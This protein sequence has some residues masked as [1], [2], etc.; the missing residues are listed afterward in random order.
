M[1]AVH[2]SVRIPDAP[3]T[4]ARHDLAAHNSHILSFQRDVDL[5]PR[6]RYERIRNAWEAIQIVRKA[7]EQEQPNSEA[8]RQWNRISAHL[9]AIYD[10]YRFNALCEHCGKKIMDRNGDGFWAHEDGEIGTA[11]GSEPCDGESELR[12]TPAH[13]LRGKVKVAA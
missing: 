8:V 13:V 2:D 6:V 12:A 1:F 5:T 11:Y 10:F 3:V 9:Y 4:I 7:R